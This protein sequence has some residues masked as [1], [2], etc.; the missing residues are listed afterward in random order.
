[1]ASRDDDKKDR[2]MTAISKI[3][4]QSSIFTLPP[5]NKHQHDTSY[6]LE[7]IQMGLETL[8]E[9]EGLDHTSM[10]RLGHLREL[11][12]ELYNKV[13]PSEEAMPGDTTNK[14]DSEIVNIDQI[15][16]ILQ[17]TTD[18]DLLRQVKEIISGK[19]HDTLDSTVVQQGLPTLESQVGKT[20]SQFSLDASEKKIVP[21]EKDIMNIMEKSSDVEVLRRVMIVSH[22]R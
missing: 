16:Q 1:V 11:I 14:S 6:I 10:T 13:I 12:E 19:L 15:K 5:I 2:L 20:T 17:N 7:A 4:E 3:L 22:T 18:Q 8:Q 21:S 9:H